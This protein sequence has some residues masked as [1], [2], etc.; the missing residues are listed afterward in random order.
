MIELARFDWTI[1]NMITRSYVA[2]MIL[3]FFRCRNK[4]PP[5]TDKLVCVLH[6]FMSCVE[7]PE[8]V[9]RWQHAE[10]AGTSN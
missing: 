8:F 4:I 2:N 5:I 1:F 6:F 9:N 10:S 3:P 7:F